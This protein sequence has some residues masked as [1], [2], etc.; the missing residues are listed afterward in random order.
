MALE[1]F[2]NYYWKVRGKSLPQPCPTQLATAPRN[3]AQ[4][5]TA[6]ALQM[7]NLVLTGAVISIPETL[8]EIW[9]NIKGLSPK[10]S[11]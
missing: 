5:K 10:F 9:S 11:S 4:Q 1:S 3:S 2:A 8:H 7:L 6:Q